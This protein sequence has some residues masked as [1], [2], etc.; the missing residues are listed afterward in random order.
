MTLTSAR[1]GRAPTVEPTSRSLRSD[2]GGRRGS[3]SPAHQPK[4]WPISFPEASAFIRRHHRHLP[5]PQGH[6]FSVAV[7]DGQQVVGVVTVGRPVARHVDDGLTLEVTRCCTT[8]AENACSM[9]YGAAWRTT[10]ALGY[11]RLITYT[12]PQ[13]PGTSLRAA[14]WRAAGVTTGG[15]WHRRERPRTDRASTSRKQVWEKRHYLS[16]PGEKTVVV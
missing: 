4:P 8:G 10:R 16:S 14:G 2:D 3:E 1:P 11:R 12:L 6:K 9:L 5:P 15:S 13:E 7:R